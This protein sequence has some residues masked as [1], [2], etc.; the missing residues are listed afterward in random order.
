MHAPNQ[1]I[2]EVILLYM[3]KHAG[4]QLI[5]QNVFVSLILGNEAWEL[6]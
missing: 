3:G 1:I 6:F 2:P 4:L 5:L